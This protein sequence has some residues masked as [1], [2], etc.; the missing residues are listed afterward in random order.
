MKIV[1]CSYCSHCDHIRFSPQMNDSPIHTES[2]PCTVVG[3][4]RF[5]LSNI[6]STDQTRAPYP[7]LFLS[8]VSHIWSRAPSGVATRNAPGF[9][10]FWVL[11]MLQHRIMPSAFL[12]VPF[13]WI[14]N[15]SHIFYHTYTYTEINWMTP[16]A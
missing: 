12:L 3:T 6:Q 5:L 1:T 4:F 10:M 14:R 15:N 9:A 13:S 11:L 7:T 2:F 16:D 8:R